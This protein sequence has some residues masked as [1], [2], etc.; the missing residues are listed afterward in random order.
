MVLPGVFSDGRGGERKGGGNSER[1][2]K[3][4]K[5]EREVAGM[6][7]SGDNNDNENNIDD[8]SDNSYRA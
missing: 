6:Y 8:G 5:V 3:L 7:D 1:Y 2:S 4:N